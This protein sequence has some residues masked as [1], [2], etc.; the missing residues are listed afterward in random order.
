[1]DS[2]FVRPEERLFMTAQEDKSVFLQTKPKPKP[3]EAERRRRRATAIFTHN[4]LD[5]IN[6]V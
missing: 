1:M 3:T 4:R 2:V 5:T 6:G